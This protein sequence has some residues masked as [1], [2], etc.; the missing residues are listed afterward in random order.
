MTEG[1][2]GIQNFSAKPGQ[3]LGKPG[4]TGHPNAKLNKIFYE[5]LWYHWSLKCVGTDTAAFLA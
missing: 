4:P 3:V 1:F 5:W 2:P